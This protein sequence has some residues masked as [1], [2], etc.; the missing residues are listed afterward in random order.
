MEENLPKN[1]KVT[2]ES[3]Y[4]GFKVLLRYMSHYRRDIVILSIMGIISAIGNGF[5]PYIAGR[6]F[7]AITSP[8][9]YAFMGYALPIFA[10]ILT[11]W[12]IVQCVTYVIDWRSN[13]MSQYL[14]N[15]IWLDYLSAGYGFLMELPIA[16]HKKH[17]MGD[18]NN[19]INTAGNALETIAGNIVI[20]LSPQI[21]SIAIALC[22][23]FWLKPFLALFLLAGLVI[24]ITVLAVKI[25]PLAQYQK[26]Y[27]K[28]IHEY[29]GDAHDAAGN[30]LAIKQATA[31]RYEQEKLV[32]KG[33]NAV[34]AWM[35]MTM[36]WS[37]LSLYQRFIILG[38]QL[39]IFTLS[40]YYIRAGV[41]TIGELIAFNA[42]AAMIFGPFVTIARNW[43]TIQN[44]II[45]IEETEKLLG[46]DPEDYH[47]KGAVNFEIKGGVKFD[48]VSFHY[49]QGKPVLEDISFDAQPGD[50]IALVGE[51]GVG[52]STLV[53]LISGYHFPEKG[54]VEIDGHD[55]RTVDLHRLR[56][57][58]AVVPQ[59]VVLFNDTIE[60]N[61]K[62]G[63]FQADEAT[64]R[65]AAR[66]AHALDFI[67]KFPDKWAQLVGERGIKL[68]VGQ[69]QRVSI[70]RAVLRDPAILILD[71]PTSAL[72]AGSEQIIT[73]SLEELMRGKT[74]FI[75]AHRL[76]TVRKADKILVF[77]EG[78]IIESGTHAELLKKED[79]EYRR[80]YELQ[81]GLH[82]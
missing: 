17:K 33:K 31:E 44:G 80:L 70:A 37:G 7:D 36:V 47:P 19:Q 30:T 79:G 51:S 76:S 15:T 32:Q 27:W 77:K 45:N 26:S 12:T 82:G 41:M 56:S 68:S 10:V 72:D 2:K 57:R 1:Q 35:R 39:V 3:L 46:Q 66:K 75:I 59:E 65:E 53:D 74:T 43:Q 38:T 20:D 8:T 16:F 40:V 9:T 62:Y 5:I 21:L 73:K 61:I 58:I 22:I 11:V 67:E 13:T 81:I 63:N 52:K 49:D 34:P 6:F 14:S 78:R 29:F 24:Y 42:Y 4:T 60:M 55:I 69:K 64:M 28:Y 50:I 71:E 25:R 54:I 23:A 18:I 48:S